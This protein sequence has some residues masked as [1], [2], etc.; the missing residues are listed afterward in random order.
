[1]AIA[2]LIRSAVATADRITK[3][4]GLQPTVQHVPITGRDA[5]GP[6]YGP[7]VPRQGIVELS[8][9][10]YTDDTGTSRQAVTKITFLQPIP[11]DL[12]DLFVV[13]GQE[14]NVARRAGLMQTD[15]TLFFSEVHLGKYRAV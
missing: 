10:Q 1:M 3:A 12:M 13:E 5:H 15:G 2:D 6:T 8:A 7:P 11:I 9:E 14:L 4:G